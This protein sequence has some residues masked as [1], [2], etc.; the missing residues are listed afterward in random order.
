MYGDGQQTRCFA[1]VTDTVEA[2]WRL[3]RCPAAR[4]QVFNV[5]GTEEVSILE[6]ARRVIAVLGSASTVEQ[7]PYE[8]AYAPGFEDMR[9]RRPAVAKLERFI[10]FR[11]AM[12]LEEIIRRTAAGV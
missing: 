5:G 2:L 4:G 9:R 10:G 1:H 3:A 7:V 12:P 8:A 6:L 11:P